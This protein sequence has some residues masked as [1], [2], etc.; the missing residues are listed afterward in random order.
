[1]R[2]RLKKILPLVLVIISLVFLFTSA[3]GEPIKTSLLREVAFTSGDFVWL[4]D[5]DSGNLRKV[6]P[7]ETSS[8]TLEKLFW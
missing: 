4:A 1:M 2:G 3:S 6:A 7:V 8:G 5:T